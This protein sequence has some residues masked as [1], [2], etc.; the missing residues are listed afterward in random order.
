[1]LSGLFL[2]AG[3]SGPFLLDDF[4][5]LRSLSRLESLEDFY[6]YNFVFDFSD[7]GSGRPVSM[8]SFLVNAGHWPD[9]A[10]GFKLVNLIVHLVNGL[11]VSFML[12]H[13]LARG[14]VSKDV[15]LVVALIV[16]LVWL[17][18]PI[19]HSTVF[20]VIQRMTEIS[21]FFTLLGCSLYIVFR[22]RVES[23]GGFSTYFWYGLGFSIILFLGVFSKENALLMCLYVVVIEFVLYRSV[24]VNNQLF[25][26]LWFFVF[27]V[28][29]II[30]VVTYIGLRWDRMI[31]QG[32]IYRDFS[33]G[34]RLFTEAAILTD[35]LRQIVIPRASGSGLF[36][37]NY[38]V[39]R[40]L[41]L[42]LRGLGSVVFLA[43]LFALGL[44]ARHKA[45]LISFGLLWFFA[46][47]VM[48]STII[49]LELYFEHR[50]YL[51]SLGI[52]IVVAGV[53]LEA[54]K[55]VKGLSMIS[56]GVFVTLIVVV[57]YQNVVVWGSEDK[58]A[59]LWASENP[60]SVRAQQMKAAYWLRNKRPDLAKDSYDEVA[61]LEPKDIS[62]RLQSIQMGCLIGDVSPTDV[63]ALIKSAEDGYYGSA[64]FGS[65]QKIDGY[66]QN[67]RCPEL[68]YSD[69]EVFLDRLLENPSYQKIGIRANI[70]YAKGVIAS[71]QR[72]LN[73]AV[74]YVDKAF[75]LNPDVSQRL[76]QAGWLASAGL[77]DAALEYVDAAETFSDS[78]RF[79]KYKS[80]LAIEEMRAAIVQ[81]KG[82]SN[83]LSH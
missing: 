38:P 54:Y 66:I 22:S 21:A 20:Y 10:Y 39:V 67:G 14:G 1:M 75:E 23:E 73:D 57:S 68:T 64:V 65:L 4:H 77:F 42:D 8:A 36:Y 78:L 37:D 6:W 31:T 72:R 50:N 45:P 44:L 81:G 25:F 51:P 76:L 79:G 27:I 62:S 26:R 16:L 60:D 43:L 5:N 63:S 74:R 30:V 41:W 28:L 71:N 69:L 13:V 19:Q 59:I 46:G 83:S 12:S 29:P 2:A 82:D 11:L 35:Y 56:A 61:A 24:S 49:P 58:I 52:L 53:F 7:S 34:E 18:H 3:L 33:L 47:H 17:V 9:Y 70:Y 40:E 15:G 80:G 55:K 32:Y 48:E